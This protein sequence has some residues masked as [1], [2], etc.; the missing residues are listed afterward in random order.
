MPKNRIDPERRRAARPTVDV[1][2]DRARGVAR[3]ATSGATRRRPARCRRPSCRRRRRGPRPSR[4]C[5]GLRYSLE[6]SWTIAGSSSRRERG[7]PR[8]AVGARGDDRRCRPRSA[9]RPSRQDVPVA[10]SRDPIHVRTPVRTGSS[11]R[12]RRPRG[13]RPSRPSS[14]TVR[15]PGEAPA[16][17]AVAHG[18]V[19]RRSES[20]RLRHESPTRSFASRITK[21][22]PA[23]FR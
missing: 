15:G 13:S 14:G 5:E 22:P 16:R 20:Q 6:C 18:G 9:R 4:S 12:S 19:N 2:R 11:K 21:R 23:R 3:T 1:H 10:L 17:Q 7:H 8:V